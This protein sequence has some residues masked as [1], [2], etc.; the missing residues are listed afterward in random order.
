MELHTEKLELKL[1]YTLL[2]CWDLSMK[3]SETMTRE[4]REAFLLS[5]HQKLEA[6]Q[7]HD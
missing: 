7:Q 3:L 6:A 4:D 1:Q 2:I 5:V